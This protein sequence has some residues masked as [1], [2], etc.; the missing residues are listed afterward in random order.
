MYKKYI[1]FICV[2]AAAT[3]LWF[4]KSHQRGAKH[5]VITQ[6]VSAVLPQSIANQQVFDRNIT[7]LVYSKHARCRM[8]CRHIDESE[9]KEILE[10]GE[11]NY[12]KIES[13]E[14]GVSYPLEGVTHD[15]QHVRIVFS[16]KE[17]G[18]AIVVTCIDLD[19]EWLCD[20]K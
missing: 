18:T 17:S 8:D 15:N 19:K 16:P 14:R 1:S 13:D 9:V 6:Q 4:V 5:E 12:K 20:C 2:L 11:V 7:K 10:K 3:L